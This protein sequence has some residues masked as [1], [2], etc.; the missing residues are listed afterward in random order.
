MSSNARLIGIG[1][2]LTLTAW[3]LAGCDPAPTATTPP[4]IPPIDLHIRVTDLADEPLAGVTVVVDPRED[5][6]VVGLTDSLG[7]FTARVPSTHLHLV[8]GRRDALAG[9][10][11]I[12]LGT[13]DPGQSFDASLTLRPA[14]VVRGIVRL[15]GRTQHAGTHVVSGDLPISTLTGADG[16][17]SI[18]GWPADVASSVMALAPGFAAGVQT[19]RTGFAGDTTTLPT[20]TIVSD[21]GGTRSRQP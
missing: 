10:S 1:L 12:D 13:V 19:F 14:C 7:R 9:S 18:D 15:A 21:P 11:A 8:Y 16:S 4:Q 2:P 5:H 6:V 20:V 3:L 17:W